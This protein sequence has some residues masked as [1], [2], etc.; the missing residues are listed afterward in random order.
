MYITLRREL[1]RKNS[2]FKSEILNKVCLEF[3]LKYTGC[4]WQDILFELADSRP[5]S[6]S[7]NDFKTLEDEIVKYIKN[8][9]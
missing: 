9:K 5:H 6:L 7:I 1:F 8:L 3:G 4:V 2:E